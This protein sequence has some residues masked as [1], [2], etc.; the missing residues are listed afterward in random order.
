MN[1]IARRIAR[2]IA[3]TVVAVVAVI[4]GAVVFG[5]PAQAE[6]NV[7]TATVQWYDGPDFA[8]V[9]LD[10]NAVGQVRN[11]DDEPYSAGVP[12]LANKITDFINGKRLD[13]H[14]PVGLAPGQF[15]GIMLDCV[16]THRAYDGKIRLY[17]DLTY[18]CG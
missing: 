17:A 11:Y 2:R 8:D 7:V 16:K 13:K 6:E 1:R 5:S 10:A 9:V 18:T 12:D 4:A 3:A 14:N 15:L